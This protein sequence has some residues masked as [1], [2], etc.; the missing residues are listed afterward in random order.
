MDRLSLSLSL[1]L[2]HTKR[3]EEPVEGFSLLN[4]G[5]VP[6]NLEVVIALSEH[7][8][9]EPPDLAAPDGRRSELTRTNLE[10]SS[11][12]VDHS[13][14]FIHRNTNVAPCTAWT[15]EKHNSYLDALEA[16]FIKQLHQSL[17]L[18]FWRSEQITIDSNPSQQLPVN[19]GYSSDQFTFLRDGPWKKIKFERNQP[20]LHGRP[21]HM[22][23]LS[24]SYWN[25]S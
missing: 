14:D 17:G 25:L 21:M 1:K 3:K 16:S 2:V 15:D 8:M 5:L 23:I 22:G 4:Q 6:L 11:V 10:S 20:L 12:T 7:A 13:K 24:L 9:A 19:A 18:P